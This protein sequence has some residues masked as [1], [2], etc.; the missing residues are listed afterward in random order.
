MDP[1]ATQFW[2]FH[3]VNYFLAAVAYTLIGRVIL[4]I[5]VPQTSDFF[6][7][8]FFRL[9]TDPFMRVLRPI[10]P[11]F[12]HPL[13]VPLYVA[14]WIFVLRLAFGLIMLYFGLAPSLVPAQA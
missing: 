1:F 13:V 11:R 9:V 14:F 5:F 6:V 4:G 12:L 7:M 2:L 3:I 10:T 8:R